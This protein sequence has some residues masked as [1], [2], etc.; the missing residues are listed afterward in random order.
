MIGE[1]VGDAGDP[2]LHLGVV[3]VHVTDVGEDLLQPLGGLLAACG[4]GLTVDLDV[5]PRLVRR[6]H[7]FAA[8]LGVD[9]EQASFDVTVD[10]QL[11]MDDPPDAGAELVEGHGDGGDQE[12]GVVGDDLDNTVLLFPTVVLLGR[13]VGAHLG[14]TGT[15]FGS[16]SAVRLG[17]AADLL[18]APSREFFRIGVP[19][20]QGEETADL[21]HLLRAESL[22]RRPLGRRVGEQLLE[23]G[24]GL[25]GHRGMPLL[26][27]QRRASTG[28]RP[29][30]MICEFLC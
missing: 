27:E 5:Y 13:G 14:T 8:D 21:V 6:H 29:S 10:G 19:V 7:A 28:R 16:E 4:V 22:P 2:V 9:V 11:G 26:C 23:N 20:V 24:V 12:G 30:H 3:L 25:L 18:G 15:T 1:F 17:G